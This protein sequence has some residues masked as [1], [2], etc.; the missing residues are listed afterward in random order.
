MR[1]RVNKASPKFI[2]PLKYD[3]A[4]KVEYDTRCNR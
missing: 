2:E 1:E 3:G 4:R